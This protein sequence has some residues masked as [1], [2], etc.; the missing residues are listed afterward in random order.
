MTLRDALERHDVVLC[1][2]AGGVGKTTTSVALA[3]AAAA[4]GHRTAVLT[5]D[6][7]RRL[8]DTLGLAAHDGMLHDVALPD[9]SSIAAMRLDVKGTFDDLVRTLSEDA[10]HTQRILDNVVYENLSTALTGTA[11]YMAVETVH[12]L[13]ATGAYD[14]I[15]VDTPPARHA[16][17]FLDAP[18]RLVALLESR[19][20]Q[21]L[22]NPASLLPAAGSRMAALLLRAVFAGLE[23]FTGLA[24]LGDVAEF[25]AL[26]EPLTQALARR[27][28]AVDRLLRSDA[29][30]AIL[31]TSPEPRLTRE[32]ASLAASLTERRLTMAGV[33]VNRALPP[34]LHA[35]A[36]PPSDLPPD[37]GRAVED[38]WTDLRLTA[39]RETE[40]LTPLLVAARAPVLATL[41]LRDVAPASLPDVSAIADELL[42]ER[43][44]D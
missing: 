40:T 43:A 10:E 33:I 34:F 2:G 11:E 12:R 23:R 24:L 38:A 16:I 41:T 39:N 15:I 4:L 30:A 44:A 7:S 20:F 13:H 27:M 36:E 25:A 37:L 6:P 31:V 5:V 22:Q 26:V 29:A 1:V 21:I 42:A 3:A 32:T 8:E 28:L 18:R 14:T 9:G 17:D 35:T 19:A